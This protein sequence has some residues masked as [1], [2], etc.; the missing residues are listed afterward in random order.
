VHSFDGLVHPVHVTSAPHNVIAH[1]F[2]NGW[3]GW[4]KRVVFCPWDTHTEVLNIRTCVRHTLL[5][6][7]TSSREKLAG[8]TVRTSFAVPYQE[9]V[10]MSKLQY[11]CSQID[12]GHRYPHHYQTGTNVLPIYMVIVFH[13]CSLCTCEINRPG[14]TA[15]RVAKHVY[16]RLTTCL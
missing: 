4:K 2:Y 7:L 16:K 11:N 10:T 6:E 14:I 9:N 3:L 5:V 15:R 8:D 12:I 1:H 13:R